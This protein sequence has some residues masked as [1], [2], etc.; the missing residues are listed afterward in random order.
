MTIENEIKKV[1]ELRGNQLSFSSIGRELGF[2][3]RTARRRYEAGL[4]RELADEIDPPMQEDF[5][6]TNDLDL[7]V[8]GDYVPEDKTPIERFT[9]LV[10]TGDAIVSS[11]W[12]IPLHDPSLINTLINCARETKTKTL[13]IGGD[14]FNMEVF[15][16]YL[17]YQPEANLDV[18]RHDGNVILKTLLRTFDNI[19]IIWGNHD[20]RLSKKLGYKKSFTECM[21]WMLSGLT[22]EEWSRVRIS[23]LDYMFYQPTGP[24][25]RTYRVCH[26][27]NF[28]SAPLVV[29]RKLASKYNSS[30]ICAHSHHIGIGFA[31]NG[32]DVC[33]E[34][35]G[36]FDKERTEYI[37]RT[38][39]HHEWTKGFTLFKDGV[40]TLI[41]P[42]FGNDLPYRKEGK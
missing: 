26:P 36:F 42:L 18:E 8:I 15:S 2:S 20:F 10:R 27:E 3:E 41:S 40:P 5:P 14:Y 38:N 30:I 16:N 11:D 19:D 13:I 4:L 24:D 39:T 25:E 9:P 23:D 31:Q 1:L 7:G 37:Q 29:S 33:I 22:D 34:A 28:S 21:E 35:G 6:V 17:P 12:H 32:V